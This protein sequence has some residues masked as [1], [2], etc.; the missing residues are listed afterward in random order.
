[1]KT[2][3]H[4]GIPSTVK[5]EG[6]I[7]M[8]DAGLFV[9][10]FNESPNLIEWLRFEEGSPMPEALQTTAHVAFKVDDLEQALEG[11][12]GILSQPG[13]QVIF[14]GFG[15]NSLDFALRAWVEDNDQFVILRSRLALAM[16]KILT[17]HNIEIPFPQRDLH[18][19]TVSSEAD[20][21]HLDRV[22]T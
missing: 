3:S 10:D 20:L 7:H 5:R 16:N 22:P 14:D 2:F 13:P 4:I 15:D 18:I 9:T 11:Q 17:E 21:K 8:E 12:E 19:K 6:E 1:M